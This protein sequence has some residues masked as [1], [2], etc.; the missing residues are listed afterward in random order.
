MRDQHT[1]PAKPTERVERLRVP[2]EPYRTSWQPARAGAMDYAALPSLH[3]GRRRAFR[4]DAP[5]RL[6]EQA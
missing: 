3:M 2:T 1:A 6:K 5:A 4:A